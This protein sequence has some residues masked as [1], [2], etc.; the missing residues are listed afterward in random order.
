MNFISK[1]SFALSSY[2]KAIS[3]SSEHKLWGYYILPAILNMGIF[4]LIGWLAYNWTSGLEYQLGEWLGKGTSDAWWR[5]ALDY[6]L[7]ILIYVLIAIVF[8]KLYKNIMLL[9]LSPALALLA[10]KTQDILQG[11][12][13][14]FNMKQ[15]I[16]DVI[17][18]I[19]IAL[20]NLVVE[21]LILIVLFALSFIPIFSPFTA[22]LMVLV[23]CFYLGFSMID[24]RN[25]YLNISAKDGRKIIKKHK[26]FSIGIG[27]GVYLLMFVPIIGVLLGPLLSVVAAGLGIHELEKGNLKMS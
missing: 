15:F 25:E 20:R 19:S 17:R 18:G 1:F 24:Y 27:M 5:V 2:K 3:F 14:P 21:I 22:V 11:G 16:N 9:L 7:T 4:T 8:L 12:E 13:K 6:G 23:E 10:E 26:W